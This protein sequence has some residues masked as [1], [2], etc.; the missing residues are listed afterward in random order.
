MGAFKF[1]NGGALV[2]NNGA[3]YIFAGTIW[4]NGF[5]RNFRTY[6]GYNLAAIGKK[7]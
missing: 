7:Q 4:L 5:K 2:I 6:A 3:F 1:G